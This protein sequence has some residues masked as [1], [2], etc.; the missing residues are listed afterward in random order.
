[1]KKKAT[2][3]RCGKVLIL[4]FSQIGAESA[5]RTC[6]SSR[7]AGIREG[8]RRP[9]AFFEN[10]SKAENQIKAIRSFYRVSVERYRFRPDRR[11]RLG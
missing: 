6:N 1:V 7:S 2:N 8:K 11:R 9:A 3:A 5:W 4:G 10:A